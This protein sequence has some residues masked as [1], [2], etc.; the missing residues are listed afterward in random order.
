MGNA[1]SVLAKFLSGARAPAEVKNAKNGKWEMQRRPR[2]F[3]RNQALG[4]HFLCISL[5]FERNIMVPRGEVNAKMGNGKC[6]RGREVSTAM[7]VRGPSLLVLKPF[8]RGEVKDVKMGNG[9]CKGR[10][11]GGFLRADSP[12]R[13][14]NAKNGKWECN[15][16]SEV[17][18]NVGNGKCN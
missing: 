3:R 18:R 6:N 11:R 1:N 12:A 7:G 10:P 15:G 9:K 13:S 14:K 4:Q 5:C 8:Q 16:R 2:G 17:P